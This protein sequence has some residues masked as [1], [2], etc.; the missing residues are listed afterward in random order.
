MLHSRRSGGHRYLEIGIESGLTLEAVLAEGIV[1]VDP[2]HRINIARL[3]G[4]MSVHTVASD[5][6]FAAVL[7]PLARAEMPA[8]LFDVVFVDGLHTFEQSYRDV[9]NAFAVLSPTGIVI[10]D[11]TVPTNRYAALPD[12]RHAKQLW[13]AHGIQNTDWM[14]DV[15]RTVLAV[16][17]FHP[18]VSVATVVDEQHRGQ[19]IMWMTPDADG[20]IP[21]LVPASRA[22][23][24]ELHEMDFDGVFAAGV[25]AEFNPSSL[26]EAIEARMRS[27]G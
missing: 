22:E 3:P 26:A 18:S 5:D 15:F 11:D 4:Q 1:G 9:L 16:R 25:P 6:Y 24:G 14:G 19:S 8:D 10:V 27:I 23:L 17:R 12:R 2:A 20:R 7:K 13:K 21:Q